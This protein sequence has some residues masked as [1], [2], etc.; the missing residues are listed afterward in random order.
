MVKDDDGHN[1]ADDDDDDD[2]DDDNDD[3]EEEEGS[4]GRGS[5]FLCRWHFFLPSKHL[6]GGSHVVSAKRGELN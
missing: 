6:H 3:D 2:N 1:D 4:L 5:G